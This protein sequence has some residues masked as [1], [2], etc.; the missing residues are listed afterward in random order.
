[1]RLMKRPPNLIFTCNP[2]YYVIRLMVPNR[3]F[4]SLSGVERLK[5]LE[6]IQGAIQEHDSF[7]YL[8]EKFNW[9]DARVRVESILREYG[10]VIPIRNPD[11]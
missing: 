6:R 8:D 5:L 7:Y 3:L 11:E 10:E 9:Q 1:M 4:A 2:D